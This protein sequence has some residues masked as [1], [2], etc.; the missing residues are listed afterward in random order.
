[1][2]ETTAAESMK[3]N[4]SPRVVSGERFDEKKSVQLLAYLLSLRTRK[5][6]PE[7]FQTN[8]NIQ[9]KNIER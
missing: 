3:A 6:G 5:F 8:H 2:S 7:N 1:V 9:A 4:L